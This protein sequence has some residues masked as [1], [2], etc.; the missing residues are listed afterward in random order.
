[1]SP[2]E[3]NPSLSVVI[4]AAGAGTRMKSALPKPLHAVAGR[5][6]LDQVLTVARE[7]ESMDITIVGSE[8]LNERLQSTAWVN[9]V[10]LATQSPPRGTADAVRIALDGGASG[11][12]VLVL[13]ADHP[14]VTCEALSELTGA[15]D[16]AVHHLAI[17]TCTVKDA[18]GYGRI[19]RDAAGCIEAV[20]EKVDD[21]PELRGGPTEINSGFM[22]LD[23][24]W[25]EKALKALRP[26]PRTNE[27]FLTDLVQMAWSKSPKSV[28]SVQGPDDL[29]IGVNDR[30]ELAVADAHL[31]A[32]K[33][34]ELMRD[35]VTLLSPD[36][37][38]IDLDVEVGADTTIG[39]GCVLESG[40]R[41]GSGCHIGPHAVIRSSTV[42][43][44]VRI[45]SSTIEQSRIDAD[46]DVGPYAHLRGG[47]H[48]GTGVHIG[49]FA[50][51]KNAT[52]AEATRIGHF[53]YIGDAGLGAGVNIGAGAVTCNFDGAE[54]HR[55]EIG[56]GA[57]IG[58]DTMLVAPVTIGA[59]A[60][61]GAG[62]VVNRDVAEGATVVGMPARRIRRNSIET[63]NSNEKGADG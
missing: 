8:E 60:R 11:S 57:F 20:V 35:G 44:R 45:E 1:M 54:K 50:E 49:N 14:L 42:G 10:S 46:S 58:S 17:L 30:I 7:L 34:R 9:G 5:P 56:D 18:A 53:S 41:I 40:T 16:P 31:H 47:T 55:T 26:N 37:S 12:T 15:F 32:R 21:D 13:Y 59:H 36:T 39:P 61:T 28:V 24:A 4:L 25:A 43:D 22:V 19:Q 51:L 52:V 2:T 62:A 27:Y 23:R 3:S 38:L 29:L 48:I 63:I 6:M 33:C